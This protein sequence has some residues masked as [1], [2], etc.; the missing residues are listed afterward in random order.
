VP[1]SVKS[2]VDS[3]KGSGLKSTPSTTAK[4]VEARAIVNAI[5]ATAVM[6]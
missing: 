4:T 3:G 6:E 1:A 2:C 5:V